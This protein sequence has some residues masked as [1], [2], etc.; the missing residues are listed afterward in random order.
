MS[1]DLHKSCLS[2]VHT[3]L[4]LKHHACFVLAFLRPRSGGE[5]VFTA[6]A[7]NVWPGTC[8]RLTKPWTSRPLGSAYLAPSALLHNWYLKR[9]SGAGMWPEPGPA[10][11][12]TGLP[13]LNWSP[14]FGAGLAEQR[15][16]CLPHTEMGSAG[17]QSSALSKHICPSAMAQDALIHLPSGPAD[18]FVLGQ[19]S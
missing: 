18:P 12:R 16:I 6:T 9:V 2:R 1:F 19:Q 15:W 13:G 3:G 5:H 11:S 17:S 7:W 8:V 10:P 14:Q 4:A